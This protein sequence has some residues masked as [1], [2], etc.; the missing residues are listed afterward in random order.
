MNKLLKTNNPVTVLIKSFE[1]KLQVSL[2]RE[3]PPSIQVRSQLT[4]TDCSLHLSSFLL[5][6]VIECHFTIETY[7]LVESLLD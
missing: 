6:N 4:Y 5:R 2:S 7:S 3:L 1:Y